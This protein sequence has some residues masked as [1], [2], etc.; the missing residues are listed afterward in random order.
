MFAS[1]PICVPLSAI[2]AASPIPIQSSGLPLLSGLGF[3]GSSLEMAFYKY[4]GFRRKGF[5]FS[6]KLSINIG[7]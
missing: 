2:A 7:F 1:R 6:P 3:D 4:R 5:A